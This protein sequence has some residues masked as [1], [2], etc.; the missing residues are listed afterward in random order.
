MSESSVT[1]MVALVDA[2]FNRGDLEGYLE[3]YADGA[4]MVIEPGRVLLGTPNLVFGPTGRP[5]LWNA[6]QSIKL[7]PGA[8]GLLR[9]W[10]GKS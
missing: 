7:D 2:A 8:I 4:V 3:F 10:S 6:P 9:V 5:M 1:E